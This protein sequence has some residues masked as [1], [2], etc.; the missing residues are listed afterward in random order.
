[1]KSWQSY[2]WPKSEERLNRLKPNLKKKKM[3]KDKEAECHISFQFWQDIFLS[4]A[5]SA[6]WLFTARGLQE[7]ISVAIASHQAFQHH[8]LH[9]AFPNHP[10]SIARMS[11]RSGFFKLEFVVSGIIQMLLVMS[12]IETNPGPATST[13]SS[14]CVASQHFNRVKKVIADVQRN[15]QTKVVT[16]TLTKPAIEIYEAGECWF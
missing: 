6:L 16:D 5:L 4:F 10:T 12:G 14:C 9:L 8:Y 1:M 15:F 7:V 2:R 13:S 11:N 3:R